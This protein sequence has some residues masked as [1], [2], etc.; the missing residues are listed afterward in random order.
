MA[1]RDLLIEI[2]TEELPP[3]SLNSLSKAFEDLISEALTSKNIAFKE[4]QRF[5]TPRRLAVIIE[6]VA[7]SQRDV[8]LLRVGPAVS[9]AYDENGKATPA[10]LGF[11]KSCNVKLKELKTTTKNGVEK[12]SYEA[13]EKGKESSALIPELIGSVLKKLPTPKR[14][15]W[16]SSKEEFVRPL[17]WI[18]LL[19]GEEQ[20]KFS[21]FGVS[22]S[23]V[24]RGHR[25]HNNTEILID[26]PTQYEKVLSE[27]GHIIPNFEKRK[28]LIRAEVLKQGSLA[29]ASAVIDEELLDE[30]T[31]LVEYPMALT[32][33][34]DSGFLRVP[35]EAL[36]LAMKKHQKCFHM[37][38]AKGNLLPK[39]ITVSNIRSKEP[40]EV[41]KGNE[42]VIRPRL[43][44]AKFFF[45]MDTQVT[46]ESRLEDLGNLIFQNKLG[47]MHDK[48]ERV[49][50]IS[51]SIAKSLSISE[52]HCERA[53]L[54]S[55]CDLLTDMVREFSDLQ[56]IIGS[57]YARHD[58]ESEEI[59]VAIQE[60]YLPRFS[61]D[62]LP[63][64]EVGSVV[65]ISDKLDTIVSLFGINQPPTGSKDPFALR[66]SAIGILRIIVKKGLDLNIAELIDDAISAQS[67]NELMPETK[68]LVFQFLLDRFR[69]WYKEDGIPST[70]FESVYALKPQRPLDF[71]LRVEAVSAFTEL[72][73]SMSLAIANKRVSNLLSKYEAESNLTPCDKNLL[74]LE[75]EINLYSQ[76]EIKK[77]EVAL[78]IESLDYTN[79][80]LCLSSLKSAIDNFFENVLVN[81]EDE[82]LRVNRYSLLF[83]LRELFLM[84]ADISFLDS[85][86]E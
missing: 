25:F 8:K 23:N 37:Y 80:L 26:E 59:A 36:I 70:V 46:L 54:L 40:L 58:G 14:M 44:D 45:E 32:G 42:R 83:E 19:F 49:A 85:N 53:S 51:K 41:I 13:L 48:V 9:S 31:S 18:L 27:V 16:G 66:R 52:A 29:N 74:R 34:F 7:E 75:S 35:P 77:E 64:S 43:S 65:A 21:A 33:E 5:A 4:T 24:T 81:D 71:H 86:Q 12:L 68:E 30:V 10:A 28:D 69:S 3:K 84:T 79:A 61:G 1:T 56:G 60:H 73:E 20:L 50:K 55:K 67:Q 78:F 6:K 72:Q 76:V 11:A 47:S 82:K 15:R 17:H 22:S 2:G 38:D 63:A 57:H 39:F 62:D